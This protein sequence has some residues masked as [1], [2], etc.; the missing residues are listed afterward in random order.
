MAIQRTQY[1]KRLT[2]DSTVRGGGQASIPVTSSANVWRGG[3]GGG[4]W[5]EQLR[6]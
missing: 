3:G 5:C 1:G 2:A 6:R 4:G